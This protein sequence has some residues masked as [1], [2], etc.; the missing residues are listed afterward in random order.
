MLAFVVYTLAFS[1]AQTVEVRIAPD[2]PA[3][4]FFTDEPLVIQVRSDAKTRAA[5]EIEAELPDGRRVSWTPGTLDLAPGRARWLTMAGLPVLRGPHV[6]RVRTAAGADP[7]VR[8]LVRIDRPAL[9]GSHTAVFAVTSPSPAMRYAAQCV[10][11]G[12]Q[13]PLEMPTLDA[14]IAGFGLPGRGPVYVRITASGG[15]HPRSIES[16]VAALAGRVD[17]WTV[18]G[19]L[20][21][22]EALREAIAV[23]EGGAETDWAVRL[24]DAREGA[25]VL[26]LVSANPPRAL[27]CAPEAADALAGVAARMGFERMPLV[28]DLSGEAAASSPEGL[29]GLVLS[30]TFAPARTALIPQCVVE[31]P[32]GFTGALAVLSALRFH[33]AGARNLGRWASAGRNDSWV[34]RL[35]PGASPDTWAIVSITRDAANPLPAVSPGDGAVWAVLDIYGN[36]LG[37][38]GQSGGAIALPSGSGARYARGHGGTLLRESLAARVRALA[39][40]GAAHA[41]DLAAVAP[42]TLG[43]LE[44]LARYTLPAPSRVHFFALLRALPAIE[45]G[46]RRGLIETRVAIPLMRDFAAIAEVLAVLEQELDE[47]L[48]EPLDKTL[49]T[50]TEWLARFPLRAGTDLMSTRR[51][52]FLRGEVARLTT[53]SR[54]WEAV[55]RV[56]EAKAVA[57]IAEWRARCLEAAATIAWPD[58]APESGVDEAAGTEPPGEPAD[59]KMEVQP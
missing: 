54:A 6:F 25:A 46:W 33:L 31:T 24:E 27:V 22:R 23:R 11:A 1:A 34:F 18:T 35:G 57:A 20:S 30:A 41:G 9:E 47:P 39:G 5:P 16:A 26:E 3:P 8:A 14:E 7:S 42:E 53:A 4:L 36:T 17:L 51:L 56:T 37:D 10:G 48:L 59:A 38:P 49:D 2:Q 58:E 13:F 28:V 55:G 50:C 43:S 19:A 44:A 52:E 45:E 12:L 15:R 29:L 32:E 21:R 40:S